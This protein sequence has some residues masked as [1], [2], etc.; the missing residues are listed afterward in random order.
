MAAGLTAL[1]LG[2]AVTLAA[3]AGGITPL[4]FIGTAIGGFGSGASFLGAYGT[5][6]PLATPSQRGA[7][8]SALYI[9]G[10]LS[11]SVPAVIAGLTVGPFGLRGATYAYGVVVALLAL[12]ALALRGTKP[13]R[14]CPRYAGAAVPLHRPAARARTADA[15]A[16]PR[17]G[18]GR[19]RPHDARVTNAAAQVLRFGGG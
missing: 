10:Y 18:V 16:K 5:L 1:V 3:L 12:S 2:M 4:F 11:F 6:V 8:I 14:A 13:E 7:L 9:V 15:G 19:A 17:A